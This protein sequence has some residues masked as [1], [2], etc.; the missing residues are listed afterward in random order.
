[1][2]D[3]QDK[4]EKKS[5]PAQREFRNN[6]HKTVVLTFERGGIDCDNPDHFKMVKKEGSQYLVPVT[7]P[8]TEILRDMEPFKK[9]SC[10]CERAAC[11]SAWSMNRPG[12]LQTEWVVNGL[13][14]KGVGELNGPPKTVMPLNYRVSREQFEYLHKLFPD[15]HFVQVKND[16]HDH[17]VSHAITQVATFEMMRGFKNSGKKI[18]DIH[19]NPAANSLLRAEL[20]LD[21][22]T[23]VS[24]ISA[25]DYVR[26][27]TKWRHGD[28]V[29]A[30]Y[31]RDMPNPEH[32]FTET[33][34]K[35]E[36]FTSVHTT[37]Y[38]AMEEI[39]AVMA[40][41]KPRAT[42]TAIMHR[43]KGDEG[44]FNN[45]EIKWKRVGGDIL[46]WNVATGESYRHPDN[47]WWFERDAWCPITDP[48]FALASSK[49]GSLAWTKTEVTPG[50]YR[51]VATICS[52]KAAAIELH[53]DTSRPTYKANHVS[54]QIG[55]AKKEFDIS[56][57]HMVLYEECKKAV[58]SKARSERQWV[59]HVGMVKSKAK[60][61]VEK[62]VVINADQ[63]CAITL[64]SFWDGFQGQ[65]EE[66]ISFQTCAQ[67]LVSQH[68]K[69]MQ[70]KNL[71]KLTN[72]VDLALDIASKALSANSAKTG[73]AAVINSIRAV[74]AAI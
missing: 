72:F 25:K 43:F 10:V 4:A 9:A 13:Y 45:G 24:L 47:C 64:A 16:G 71:S 2:A 66:Q 69:S 36:A 40:A 31:L 15:Y 22:T 59:A 35:V 41:A 39:H 42:W 28:Y 65:A 30:P 68:E 73:T 21:I 51:V 3:D 48:G 20:S 34:S 50:T 7:R 52:D 44:S 61:L 49:M 8:A 23:A 46:Q 19:G 26:A 38:Y 58:S 6:K 53:G 18:L 32:K 37:Y 17:P 14:H 74:N 67:F 57:N 70:G 12:P 11:R 62:G 33:L 5:K 27:A 29:E 60:P 54:V 63:L 56:E 55:L 1:V